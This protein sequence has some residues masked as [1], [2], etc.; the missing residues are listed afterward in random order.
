VHFY[1]QKVEKKVNTMV[2]RIREGPKKK[3][4]RWVILKERYDKGR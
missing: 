1:Q 2:N 4:E 3:P